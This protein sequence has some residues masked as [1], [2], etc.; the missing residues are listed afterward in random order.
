[1]KRDEKQEVKTK[2]R[3]AANGESMGRTEQ[4]RTVSAASS[5]CMSLWGIIW[6]E[7]LNTHL[8]T[9]PTGGSTRGI[10]HWQTGAYL[11]SESERISRI[12]SALRLCNRC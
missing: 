5:A 11:N 8:A 2:V 10:S 6:P 4:M 1:M 3:E 9:Q 12:L 7:R